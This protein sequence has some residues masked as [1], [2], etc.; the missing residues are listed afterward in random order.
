MRREL[1]RLIDK[2]LSLTMTVLAPKMASKQRNR[3]CKTEPQTKP[4]LPIPQKQNKN[5]KT[6]TTNRANEQAKLY[7]Q[8]KNLFSYR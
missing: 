3:Q 5:R 1:W 8:P 6:A 2:V 7:A 4:S